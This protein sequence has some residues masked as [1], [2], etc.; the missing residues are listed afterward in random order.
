MRATAVLPR[1]LALVFAGLLATGT[2]TYGAERAR[3]TAQ[4]GKPAAGK[5]KNLLVPD[6]QGKPYVFAEGMLEEKGFAWR[7]TGSVSGYAA[8]TVVSQTPAPGARVVDTGAPTVALELRANPRYAQVGVPENAAPFP[9][10][11]IRL[12]KVRRHKAAAEPSKVPTTG[13]PGATATRPPAFLVP[14]APPEPLSQPSLPRQARQLGAWLEKH[15]KATAA[16]R[17][18]LSYEN[19]LIVSGARFGWS[20]GAEALRILIAVDKRA[21][22]AW[23]SGTK[24]RIQAEKALLEVQARAR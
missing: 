14:G 8:N 15:P 2:L 12:P 9:G 17:A 23:R 21:E 22:R 10:T 16:N 5:P 20:R 18:H 13:K 19:W 3:T 7:V 4:K 11:A 6:V 1:L 24:D